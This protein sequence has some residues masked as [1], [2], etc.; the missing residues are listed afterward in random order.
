MN[1]VDDADGEVPHASNPGDGGHVVNKWAQVTQL[2]LMQAASIPFFFHCQRH[3][4][5]PISEQA[6]IALPVC[7]AH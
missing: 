2:R 7:V 4:D 3:K 1:D 5:E 6:R